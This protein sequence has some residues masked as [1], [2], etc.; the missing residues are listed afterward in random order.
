MMAS[1]LENSDKYIRLYSILRRR[2]NAIQFQFSVLRNSLMPDQEERY[3]AEIRKIIGLMHRLDSNCITSPP[4]HFA[5]GE[6]EYKAIYNVYKRYPENIKDH[7]IYLFGKYVPRSRG[8]DHFVNTTLDNIAQSSRDA[9][10]NAL[11][12]RLENEL[13]LRVSQGWFV[14]FNTLTVRNEREVFSRKSNA[15]KNYVRSYQRS[16]NNNLYNGDRSKRDEVGNHVYFAVV[17]TGDLKGRLHIHSVHMSKVLPKGCVDPNKGRLVPYFREIHTIKKIWRYGWSVPI[18]VRFS[19]FDAY[20]KIGWVMPVEKYAQGT[21]SRPIK[22]KPPTA[23]ARYVGKYLK[24]QNDRNLLWKTRMT[25]NLGMMTIQSLLEELNT[26]ELRKVMMMIPSSKMILINNQIQNLEMIRRQAAKT[27]LKR[28]KK[29]I[30]GSRI[31]WK[32]I[33]DIELAMGLA[34]QLKILT[35]KKDKTYKQPNIMDLSMNNTK[36]MGTFNENMYINVQMKIK[37]KYGDIKLQY[38]SYG[39]PV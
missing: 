24:K 26:S 22:L 31:A 3:K 36:S 38:T 20:S 23:L 10:K 29:S 28:M 35:Q 12:L 19:D 15:W 5:K 16:V 17:E 30:R 14:V 2:K 33:S 18:A 37:E 11:I 13:E 39:K 27:W 34:T 8:T 6:L 25:N 4:E 32:A 7:S 21:R 1:I 9:R